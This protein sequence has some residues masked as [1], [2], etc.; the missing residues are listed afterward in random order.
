M[1]IFMKKWILLTIAIVSCSLSHAE[2]PDKVETLSSKAI[3]K[4]TNGY[5]VLSDRS[6]WKA[7]GFSKRW[8]SLSE[9]W[10]DVKLAPE[11]YECVPN[12]WFLGTQ[13]EVYSKVS[14]LDVSESNASNQDSLKQCTHLLVNSRTGQVLFAIALEPADCIVQLFNE[15]YEDGYGKGYDKGRLSSYQ[16]ANDI[17]NKGQA[18][19]YKTGY[20]DG[21]RAGANGEQ[22]GN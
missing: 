1:E 17:Y 4:N 20:K 22:P 8:R 3:L 11:K 7:I 12:D 9:W 19:G 6:C 21:Y 2:N 14:N 5:F 15:A 16:N 18:E 10:N 13:I